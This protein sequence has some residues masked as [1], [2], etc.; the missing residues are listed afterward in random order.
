MLCRDGGGN[1]QPQAIDGRRVRRRRPGLHDIPVSG[2]VFFAALVT[3][4]L[5]NVRQ[6]ETHKR[7][8]LVATVS[9]LQAAVGRWL[10]ILI[11][12][13]PPGG[14]GPVVPPPVFVTIVPALLSDVLIVAAMMHDRKTAGRVHRVYWLAG[15]A[16]VALQVLRAPLSTSAA[17]TRVTDWLLTVSL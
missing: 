2:I 1:H 16:L 4:A 12:P 5:L 15:G 6:L 11:A 17:W 13:V 10:V 8:M 9:L 3:L 7:L 14:G